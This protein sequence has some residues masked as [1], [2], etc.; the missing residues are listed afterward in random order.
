MIPAAALAALGEAGAAV[1]ALEK[2]DTGK[3]SA[4]PDKIG[5]IERQI[6][7][8][9]QSW[10]DA[11][12]APAQSVKSLGDIVGAYTKLSNPAQAQLYQYRIENTFATIGRSMEG[13]MDSISQSAE[14]VGDIY[15]KLEPAIRPAIDGL[16]D[17]LEGAISFLGASAKTAAPY[18]KMLADRTKEWGESMRTAG[19]LAEWAAPK[20]SAWD[21]DAK[22]AVAAR[23]PQYSSVRD[24]IRDLNKSSILAGAKEEEKKQTYL[25]IDALKMLNKTMEQ[26]PGV[27]PV[28]RG[29]KSAGKWVA[30]QIVDI[31]PGAEDYLP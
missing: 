10:A 24:I 22:S 20:S 13:L 30:G 8:T 27:G 9:A 29:G 12:A 5:A 6:E 3:L 11:M 18:V 28:L 2:V 15:A 26:F 1:G 31:P 7:H 14:K 19:R 21:E 4:V 25:L 23:A 17:S 16:S